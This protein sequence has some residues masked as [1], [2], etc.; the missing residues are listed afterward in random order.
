[1]KALTLA[2][3][4]A[5]AF[6]SGLAYG[7]VQCNSINVITTTTA[8][9]AALNN[10]MVCVGGSGVWD[11]QEWHNSGTT[12]GGNIA[13]YKLGPG[14]SKDPSVANYGSYKLSTAGSSGNGTLRATV[15]YT[16]VNG[17]QQA[18]LWMISTNGSTYYYCLSGTG[19]VTPSFSASVIAASSDTSCGTP[20]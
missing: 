5:M 11:N 1:M 15:Q 8:M 7:A 10:H 18:K 2:V 3:A 4:T 13:E 19:N 14:P 12:S 9:N 16:Y 17:G 20:P 6:S